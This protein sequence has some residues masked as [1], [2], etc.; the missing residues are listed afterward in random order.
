MQLMLI[1]KTDFAVPRDGGALRTSQIVRMLNSAGH[2][3]SAFVAK[4]EEISSTRSG[5]FTMAYMVACAKVLL[6][7]VQCRSLTVAKWYSPSLIKAIVVAE[8]SGGWDGTIVEYSQLAIYRDIV[9]KPILVDMHNIESELMRNYQQSAPGWVRKT[10]ARWESKRLALLESG[11]VGFADAITLVSRHDRDLLLR[12]SSGRSDETNVSLA[13][14]PNGVADAGFRWSGERKAHVV[15]VAHLGWQPNIDAALWLVENVWERVVNEV[16]TAVLQLVGRS[17]HPSILAL[18]SENVQIFPDV[19]SVIPFTGAATVATAPLLASGGTR[20]KIMEA[21]SCGTPVVAT[22]LGALGLESKIGEGLVI[23][24]DPD[25][26]AKAIVA[27][28]QSPP[29][30]ESVRSAVL[31]MTWELTL[32][33]LVEMTGARLGA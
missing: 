10:A 33:P 5:M 12:M 1:T 32:A 14:A 19:D 24:N 4:P 6:R 11:I 20:L 21:M 13:I 3:V 16:P 27:I 31:D 28:F 7:V 9:P 17:P 18:A 29:P 25:E 22:S 23:A 2:R 26:F 15:F 30:R 8:S